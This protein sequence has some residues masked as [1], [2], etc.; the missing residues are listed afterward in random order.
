MQNRYP[1]DVVAISLN[2][3]HEEGEEPTP[4]LR[5]E[6]Q[7]KLTELKITAT[8][9]MSVATFDAALEHFDLFSLPAAIV[10]D[11]D[12]KA[13]KVFEGDLSYDAQIFP[14]LE[15]V[16]GPGETDPD[17]DS[18]DNVGVNIR[19]WDE[20]EAWVTGQRGKVVVVDVWSTFCGPCLEEFPH[21]VEL[22]N[23]LGDR[24][25]CASLN[26]DY[27]G[28]GDSPAEI[29]PRVLAFLTKQKATST[30]FLSSTADEVVL[31]KLGFAAL[32]VTLVYSQSGELK[33]FSND[34][35]R[36]GPAGF[37]YE[38]HINPYVEQTLQSAE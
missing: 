10:F 22:H 11:R 36:F 35:A 24:V 30:N 3:D 15:E 31:D 17:N 20:F 27:Y 8:N 26:L 12:G 13:L 29:Q 7:A 14:L 38:K 18:E 28:A 4:E 9:V 16:I 5:D 2:L 6:V 32:P 25:V 33:A 37:S 23:R 19:D 1:E 34:D 21:F